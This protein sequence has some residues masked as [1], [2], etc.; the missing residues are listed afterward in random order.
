MQSLTKKRSLYLVTGTLALLFAGIIYGWSILKVPLAEQFGLDVSQL[1]LNYTLTMCFFCLGGVVGSL[2]RSRLGLPLT[3]TVAAV[4]SAGG[5]I[6]T[7]LVFK[8]SAALLYL[9]YGVMTGLGIGIAYTSILT[10]VGRWFPDRTGFCSGCL[11]MGFGASTLLLGSLADRLIA[12]PFGWQRT[13]VLIGL[14][15]L[16]V[17]TA[18][19]CILRF[20]EE[21]TVFPA[22][23]ADKK[24]G[25][26]KTKRDCTTREMMSSTAFWKAFLF[27]VFLTAV[28][29]V[30]IGFARD[31]SVE[32]GAS[33]AAA[34][35]MVGLLSVCNGLGRILTGLVFDALGRRKTMLLANLLTIAAS[36]ILL[37]SVVSGSFAV[38]CVGICTAGLSYGSCPT[39]VSAFTAEFFGRKH[40]SSNFSIMNCNLMLA[41]FM[42]T[43]CGKLRAATGGFTAALAVL[44]VLTLLALVL[45]LSINKRD[46]D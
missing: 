23:A 1:A 4:L 19:G 40:Y 42:A 32:L 45:N 22:S 5:F 3:F 33:S 15:L 43:V 2:I 27:F 26:E 6:L 9:L 25:E 20:P 35:L 29:S 8:G 37:V 12:A 46:R 17:L 39:M 31:L 14:C 28:G 30:A 10:V 38:F 16:L 7:G 34:A 11:M 24:A 21:G 18:T 36:L 41:A 13:Y 44:S